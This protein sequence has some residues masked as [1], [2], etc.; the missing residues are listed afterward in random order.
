MN[1]VLLILYIVIST[2]SYGQL[3]YREKHSLL[4]SPF[5]I[6]VVAKDSVQAKIW[7]KQSVD[8]LKRIEN[9][10]SEWKP[11]SEVSAINQNA[12]IAPVKVSWEVFQLLERA[13]KFSK[14]TEGAFDISFASM[15][16]I[17]KFDGSMKQM[18]TEDE[19]KYS[20]RNVGYKNIILKEKDTTVFLNK[21][22]MKIGT[23][24]IGQGYIADKIKTL[25]KSEGCESGLVNISG[26][27]NTWGMQPDGNPWTVAIV[28]PVN[29][30]NVF[31]YFPLIDSAVETS[32]NYEKYV[33]FNGIRYSH[34]IDP[35][36]GYPAQGVASVSVFAKH[37]EIA[38]ALATGVFVLGV[39]V[40]IDLINQLDGIECIIIDNAGKIYMSKGIEVNKIKS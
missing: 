21:S 38:D 28:N 34:I 31:A 12:G 10:I 35:R 17:W 24:G 13:V 33:E 30:E 23:G 9:L 39:E 37:T 18:P 19:V 22:G 5:E 3:V 8:E 32:G 27:I 25:L 36:T 20:V 6:T 15:D 26:D 1:K 29:K 11:T 4:G 7:A 40:G 2:N 16:K 14:L